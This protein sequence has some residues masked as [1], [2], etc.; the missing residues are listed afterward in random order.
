[1][2]FNLD[3]LNLTGAD[4]LHANHEFY[5]DRAAASGIPP[6]KAVAD[7]SDTPSIRARERM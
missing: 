1:M 6:E 4:E 2:D 7:L 3:E 5:L